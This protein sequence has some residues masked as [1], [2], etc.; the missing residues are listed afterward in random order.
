[1][2]VGS[3]WP[4]C[5]LRRQPKKRR[6]AEGGL[7]RAMGHLAENTEL[8][9]H[10]VPSQRAIQTTCHES[11]H[12]TQ[13]SDMVALF[14]SFRKVSALHNPVRRLTVSFFAAFLPARLTAFLSKV[15]CP[16]T[17]FCNLTV[18][19][20]GNGGLYSRDSAMVQVFQSWP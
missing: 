7:D 5:R 20:S 10:L 9:V 13:A 3:K 6:I 19:G 16:C 18:G 8:S 11:V 2:V 1:M 15:F 12:S 4:H 17:D 14:L